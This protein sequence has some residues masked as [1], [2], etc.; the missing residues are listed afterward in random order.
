MTETRTWPSNRTSSLLTQA[1]EAQERQRVVEEQL[2]MF[3]ALLPMLLRRLSKIRD[4]RNPRA[5]KHK[6]SVLLVWGLLT[7]VLQMSSRREANRQMTMPMF[8]QNLM[9]MFPEIESLPH[10]DTLNRV[11]ARM[12]DV[13]EIQAAQVQLL[14]DLI[15]KKKF[16]RYLWQHRYLVA[17]DGTQKFTRDVAWA[18]QASR[19][20]RT[21][22][23]GKKVQYFVY[24]LEANLVFADGITVPLHTEFLE[25]KVDDEGTERARQDCE[26]KAFR[27]FA[28]WL[29][30]TFP[31]LPIMLLLDGLYP[32]G[33]VMALCRHYNWQYM[34]V[35]QDRSLP[36]V[37][38]E[39]GALCRLGSSG[40]HEMEHKKRRQHFQWV[41]DIEYD[42]DNGRRRLKMHVVVCQEQWQEESR[43]QTITKRASR[44]A[45]ISSDPLT[46]NNVHQRC[47]R[48]ARRRWAIENHIRT[49]KHLD[50]QYE[51]IFSHDWNAMK[52]YHYL[53]RLAHLMNTLVQLCI[54]LVDTVSSMGVRAFIRF[55]RDTLSG[56]WLD[57]P[58]IRALVRKPQHQIRL[59]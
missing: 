20:T 43:D 53:M 21:T 57:L 55:T 2:K 32:S 7:F 54:H 46:E 14:K 36:T 1:D 41:N 49:E 50:Y 9:A 38:H 3:R 28:S 19:R 59:A 8:R 18:E 47:N 48:A 22:R 34:I 5:I 17:V 52:G 29:K 13:E 11:L 58:R 30:K 33:P 39:F 37:W 42:Y 35:L 31:R 26:L 25:Y 27:R 23:S 56:P 4:P 6:M 15:R 40:T 10:H 24:A 12:D 51:H 44:H 45:W 16:A